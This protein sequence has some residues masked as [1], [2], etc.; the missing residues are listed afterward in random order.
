[1]IVQG[2]FTLAFQ[3]CLY[4][5]LIRLTTPLLTLFLFHC[6]LLFNSLH[7]IVLYYHNT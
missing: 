1:L 7:C 4:C 6:R 2:G 3:I 5:A